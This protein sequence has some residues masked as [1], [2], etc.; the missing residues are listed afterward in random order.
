MPSQQRQ[1]LVTLARCSKHRSSQHLHSR[2]LANCIA[3]RRKQVL[4][5]LDSRLLVAQAQCCQRRHGHQLWLVRALDFLGDLLGLAQGNAR[6]ELQDT[7]GGVVFWREGRRVKVVEDGFVLVLVEGGVY[8]DELALGGVGIHL[9][10]IG[11]V[12]PFVALR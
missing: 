6:P 4:D 9:G 8:V 11:T 7:C 12:E 1:C 10:Q 3:A 2:I 5:S